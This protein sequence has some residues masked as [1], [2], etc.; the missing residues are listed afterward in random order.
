MNTD[1]K[2]LIPIAKNTIKALKRHFW[3]ILFVLIG[4][5]YGLLIFNIN[6]FNRQEP[7]NATVAQR[8]EQVPR[9]RIDTQTAEKLKKLEDNSQEVRSLFQDARDN[10]FT[11]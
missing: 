6:K 4:G 10:P 8:I 11:E 9:P 1:I 5:L 2:A 3:I 7:D